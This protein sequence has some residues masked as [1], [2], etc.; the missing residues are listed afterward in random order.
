MEEMS[1]Y[2]RVRSPH[3]HGY[4]STAATDFT[5]IPLSDERAR[6]EVEAQHILRVEPAL[7]REPPARLAIRLNMARVLG[8][9]RQKA[10][11]DRGAVQLGSAKTG[12]L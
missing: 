7:Y 10:E 2:R 8:D 9:V 5:L 3:V 6:L 4:F 12:S 11:Q 1:P